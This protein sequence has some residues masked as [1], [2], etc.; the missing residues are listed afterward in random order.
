MND[1]KSERFIRQALRSKIKTEE[2]LSQFKKR[3]AKKNGIGTPANFKIV[4]KYRELVEKGELKENPEFLKLLRK[5]KIRSLAG[6]SVITAL[7]K[8]YYCPGKCIFCPT[9]EDM[10][11][12]YL[13]NEPGAMRAVLNDFDPNRQV[14]SRLKSLTNQGH[15]TDKIELIVLGGTFSAYP[16]SYQTAFIRQLYN[17]LN[18]TKYRS[19]K[20]AQQNN[21]IA[22]HR[23]IALSL[24][25]RP[26]HITK[27][28]LKR[29]R[30]YG[31]TKLQIG[32]QSLHDDVLTLN[33]RG[34]TVEQGRKAIQLSRD[35]GF[36]FS[37]HMMP[38]LAGSTPERDYEM[39]KTLF[40]DPAYKPDFL[41]LYPC[42]VVP[43]SE[44]E[45]WWER[46]E[47]QPY[48]N[49][50]LTNLIIEIKKIVPEFVRID[51]LVRDIPGD[52]ILAGNL[53]TNLR[54][55]IQIEQKN[56]V[57][58]CIRC[59]EIRNRTID[60]NNITYKEQKFDAAGGKEFFLTYEEEAQDKLLSLLR[61]R[62]PSQ[63]FTGKKHF[64]KELEGAAIIREIHT[65]GFQV[66]IGKRHKGAPQH[67]G[68][69]QKL[70]KKAESIT[71][72]A[73]IK[74][75]AVIA[76]I[77]TREYYRKW[78]YQLEGTYMVKSL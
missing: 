65:Y 18:G 5:R 70:I 27:K 71:R 54:Q 59:R 78:G 12:S 28:E 51:R 15:P 1:K 17:S 64:I 6:V 23:C 63:L 38:N 26:D 35:A 33:K 62:F 36:K 43:F 25:T 72:K 74:K 77:G 20:K 14:G 73:G 55:L 75:L 4:K 76:A 9:E 31:C 3:F 44:L 61:L 22:K 11:K 8:P 21:E 37:V 49:E 47:Y 50:T 58:R 52:S 30:E 32:L 53:N 13:S 29:F 24:E 40:E 48:D 19:L 66:G 68:L 67:L 60:P 69:G 56:W 39:M 41:K 16:H 10:P 7:T 57:C 46:G 42:T 2:D 45:K 34:E